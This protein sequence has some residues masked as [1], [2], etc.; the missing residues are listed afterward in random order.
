[1]LP[2]VEIIRLEESETEGT[3]GILRINKSVFCATLEPPDLLNA[4]GK[5]SIPAQQYFCEK[6]RSNKFGET[7]IVKNVPG[8]VGVLFHSGNYVRD[9]AGCIILGETVSKLRGGDRGVTNSGATFGSFMS[10]MAGAE[11]FHLTIYEQY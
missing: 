4:V 3:F 10:K 9:T 7:F 8:R 11:T 6:Y 2:I 5:S 1:M